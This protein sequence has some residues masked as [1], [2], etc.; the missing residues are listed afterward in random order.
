MTWFSP[1]GIESIWAA[2]VCGWRAGGSAPLMDFSNP[3]GSSR[4]PL[5]WS[6]R[7]PG[8]GPPVTEQQCEGDGE[9]ENADNSL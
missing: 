3:I 2:I 5:G 8:A 6:K 9:L 4:C 1:V 7:A